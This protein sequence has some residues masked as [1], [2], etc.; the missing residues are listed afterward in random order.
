VV[1][2]IAWPEGGIYFLMLRE[3]PSLLKDLDEY[4]EHRAYAENAR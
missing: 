1:S 4:Q 2:R 3:K